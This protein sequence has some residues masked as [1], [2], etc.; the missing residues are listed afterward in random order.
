MFSEMNCNQK[1]NHLYFRNERIEKLSMWNFSQTSFQKAQIRNWMKFSN[2]STFVIPFFLFTETYIFR[3]FWSRSHKSQL[4]MNVDKMI[5]LESFY[6]E[7]SPFPHF[8]TTVSA[9]S[10]NLINFLSGGEVLQRFENDNFR[11]FQRICF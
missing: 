5:S 9:S 6:R 7:A 1:A 3:F 8:G 2:E 4:Q 10:N 11:I